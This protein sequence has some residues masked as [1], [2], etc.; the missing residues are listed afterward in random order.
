L[1]VF[2]VQSIIEFRNST[3][4]ALNIVSRKFESRKSARQFSN[5]INDSNVAKHTHFNK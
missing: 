1:S 5:L 2:D 3:S 4:D